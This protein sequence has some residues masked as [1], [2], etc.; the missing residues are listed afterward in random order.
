MASEHRKVFS[1][2][3]AADFSGFAL[4]RPLSFDDS[5]ATA[6]PYPVALFLDQA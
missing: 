1:Y 3:V 4:A 5:E 2:H 6:S